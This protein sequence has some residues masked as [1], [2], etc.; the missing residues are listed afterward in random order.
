MTVEGKLGRAG[1]VSKNDVMHIKSKMKSKRRN[2]VNVTKGSRSLN[3]KI[4][5][6]RVSK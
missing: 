1:G 4:K 2:K 5:Y 3:I 6:M